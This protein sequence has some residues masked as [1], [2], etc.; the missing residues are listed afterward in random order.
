[1]TRQPNVELASISNPRDRSVCIG[2]FLGETGV[3]LVNWGSDSIS[4][5]LAHSLAIFID[6]AENGPGVIAIL[7][8]VVATHQ[9]DKK[10]MHATIALAVSG[11]SNI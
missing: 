7:V 6:A 2:L 3:L 5:N 8:G 1:M 11:T 10:W 4:V 9:N